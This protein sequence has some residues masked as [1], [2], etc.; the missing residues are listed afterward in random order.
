MSAPSRVFNMLDSTS[1]C[2][3]PVSDSFLYVQVEILDVANLASVRAFAD[4]WDA[5]GRPL[6]ALINNAGIFTLA[7]CVPPFP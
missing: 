2:G 7:G 5:S 3:T 1:P 4:R 6:H